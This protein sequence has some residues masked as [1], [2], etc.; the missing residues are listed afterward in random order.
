[1]EL[2]SIVL[3]I[4]LSTVTIAGGFAASDVAANQC[5][6]FYTQDRQASVLPEKIGPTL[7]IAAAQLAASA[8]AV[9]IGLSKFSNSDASA[10]AAGEIQAKEIH[11]IIYGGKLPADQAR[12]LLEK[13][14]SSKFFLSR[15]HELLFIRT[16]GL[17]SLDRN[18]KADLSKYQTMLKSNEPSDRQF[19]YDLAEKM[20]AHLLE[21]ISIEDF[22]NWDKL[23]STEKISKVNQSE[24]GRS[25]SYPQKKIV[26]EFDALAA[27]INKTGGPEFLVRVF[28]GSMPDVY[29]V[30]YARAAGF[31]NSAINNVVTSTSLLGTAALLYLNGSQIGI[32]I[33]GGVLG[34]I[35]VGGMAESS[36]FNSNLS[37]S[38]SN[39]YGKTA[40]GFRGLIGRR[41][42]ARNVRK[43]MSESNETRLLESLKKNDAMEPDF[44]FIKKELRK[45]IIQ[46]YL[47][48]SVWSN[49]LSNG[50]TNILNHL[51]VLEQ[52]LSVVDEVLEP[53]SLRLDKVTVGTE[54]QKDEAMVLASL[55]QLHTL[56]LEFYSL[57]T[58]SL[59]L[60]HAMDLY[61]AKIDSALLQ[62]GLS[63]V[64]KNVLEAKKNTLN[65][66]QTI[67]QN[68]N[69]RIMGFEKLFLDVSKTYGEFGDIIQM[70]QL[71]KP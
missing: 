3:R 29:K 59:A 46:N 62:T 58:N 54:K 1:M 32:L 19:R 44:E 69:I 14:T 63:D 68:L 2:R 70:N 55:E 9:M 24:T 47:E 25:L 65:R 41:G 12:V 7:D 20:F 45:D 18:R 11:K 36:N 35:L 34:A 23:S 56:M 8:D 31:R 33:P 61:I 38:I 64:Q 48:L 26:A 52:K 28:D 71:I 17:H 51:A 6:G 15:L 21:I 57:K 22:A 53:L 67:Y 37:S 4:I 60:A 13:L 27:V 50:I 39:L 16:I 30:S 40:G 49:G 42:T 43:A 10:L 66:K 5:L